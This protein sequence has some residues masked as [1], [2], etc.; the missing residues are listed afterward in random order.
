MGLR[1]F[2]GNPLA[3]VICSTE[4]STDGLQILLVAAVEIITGEPFQVGSLGLL[5]QGI[6]KIS[7]E[8]FIGPLTALHHFNLF[9]HLLGQ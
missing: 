9:G 4:F 5:H 7:P 2:I 6:P 1:Q 3:G 8:H